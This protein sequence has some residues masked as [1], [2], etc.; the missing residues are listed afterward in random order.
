MDTTTPADGVSEDTQPVETTEA[1][2]DSHTDDQAIVLDDNGT[3]ALVP[4]EEA[5]AESEEQATDPPEEAPAGDKPQAETDEQIA[6]WAEKKGLKINPENP[7]EV[8]LARMQLENERQF[9]AN[10]QRKVEPPVLLDAAED[11]ALNTVIDRQNE[12]ET[13]LYVRDWFDANPD[14]KQ[15]RTELTQISAN[16]PYLQDM[17]D[18]A[19]HLYRD[20]Q[21]SAKLRR[22]GGRE[23]LTNLAQK[24]QAIPPSSGASNTRVFEGQTITPSNV[25]RLVGEHDQAWFEKHHKEISNAMEGK[26]NN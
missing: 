4:V 9:H 2:A 19:A 22:E 23:A 6:E 8:K 14:M 3:P 21:F 20:P 24:Q 17:D 7:N 10:Q 18:V 13:K 15:Y 11:P 12:A 16:R 25:D 1:V 26:P 5:E